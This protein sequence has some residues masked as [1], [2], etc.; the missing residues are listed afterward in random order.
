MDAEVLEAEME[1][2]DKKMTRSD[3]EESDAVAPNLMGLLNEAS[4]RHQE[5]DP[6]LPQDDDTQSHVYKPVPNDREDEYIL[7]RCSICT[8]F[9]VPEDR[10]YVVVADLSIPLQFPLNSWSKSGNIIKYFLQSK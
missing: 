3:S 1:V 4:D 5:K 9:L 10:I 8:T 7:E 2:D 6:P